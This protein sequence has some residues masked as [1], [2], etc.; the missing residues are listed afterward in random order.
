MNGNP[1]SLKLR[2]HSELVLLPFMAL[3]GACNV[4][5]D[6]VPTGT[7]PYVESAPNRLLGRV[8]DDQGKP[9]SGAEILILPSSELEGDVARAVQDFG[10]THVTYSDLNGVFNISVPEIPIG[11]IIVAMII[12]RRASPLI[13]LSPTRRQLDLV[14]DDMG[15]IE[16]DI[17]PA[18][19]FPHPSMLEMRRHGISRDVQW[20]LLNNKL[21][22]ISP[23]VGRHHIVNGLPAGVYDLTITVDSFPALSVDGVVIRPGRVTYDERL[24]EVL[25][26]RELQPTQIT[27]LT[28]DQR[29]VPN[30]RVFV[31]TPDPGWFDHEGLC[32]QY[33]TDL[34]GAA[35][36]YLPEGLPRYVSVLADGFTPWSKDNTLLPFTVILTPRTK[37]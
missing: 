5:S 18:H 19:P 27:V 17:V 33:L 4:G 30:A 6:Q 3:S 37:H 2:R 31:G 23:I 34:S 28:L 16:V 26:G 14:V 29:P 13:Q 22:N 21:A 8:V 1:I 10:S 11:S 9:V 20:Q 15:S 36:I 24:Q 35:S 32:V 12:G 25:I 7:S